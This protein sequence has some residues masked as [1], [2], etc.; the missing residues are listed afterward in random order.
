[1]RKKKPPSPGLKGTAAR[2]F[3]KFSTG[4]LWL[5]RTP[6]QSKSNST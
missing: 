3:G 1:M 6:P 5:G 2:V 4:S